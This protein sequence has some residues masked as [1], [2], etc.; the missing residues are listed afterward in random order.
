MMLV[1]SI[2]YACSIFGGGHA[3]RQRPDPRVHRLDGGSIPSEGLMAERASLQLIG[4]VL[5]GMT[6]GVIVIAAML[7][8]R[9]TDI[10][11]ADR[12]VAWQAEQAAVINNT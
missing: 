9:S 6:A 7:V 10:Q 12:P 8:F 3:R 4:L 11:L 1:P 2:P 5:A